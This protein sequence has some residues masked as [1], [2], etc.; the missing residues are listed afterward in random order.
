MLLCKNVEDR[1]L[2]S[3]P[4]CKNSTRTIAIEMQKI[5]CMGGKKLESLWY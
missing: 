4:V 2:Q 3:I 5:F 1:S